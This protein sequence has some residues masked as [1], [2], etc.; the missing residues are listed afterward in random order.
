MPKKRQ[1]FIHRFRAIRVAEERAKQMG[2]HARTAS[3]LYAAGRYD[4]VDQ[5]LKKAEHLLKQ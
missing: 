4:E 2:K 3:E 1:N 5:E